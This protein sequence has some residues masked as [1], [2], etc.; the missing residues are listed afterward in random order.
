M[1]LSE[2]LL[3]QHGVVG[4]HLLHLQRQDPDA[5]RDLGHQLRRY[6]ADLILRVKQHGHQGGALPARRI[7]F[8]QLLETCFQ[9]GGERHRSLS[10]KTKSMLPMAAITSAISVP[11]TMQGTACR[12]PKLGP[13]TCTRNG[14]DVPSLTK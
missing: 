7:A 13:R 5:M 10:P 9:F 1:V 8:E 12:L 6:R 2:R 4:S 11:S 14:L 3:V